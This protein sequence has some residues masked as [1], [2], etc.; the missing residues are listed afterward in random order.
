VAPAPKVLFP[1]VSFIFAV[2]FIVILG[3]AI[4]SI[5]INLRS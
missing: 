2:L 4:T 1:L 5:M 3:P